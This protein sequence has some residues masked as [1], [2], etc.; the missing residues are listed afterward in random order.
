MFFSKHHKSP[1][2]IACRNQKISSVH[3]KIGCFLG[4]REQILKFHFLWN[5]FNIHTCRF[6]SR[7]KKNRTGTCWKFHI[8]KKSQFFSYQVTHKKNQEITKL[9]WHWKNN[10]LKMYLLLEMVIFQCHVR[11]QGSTH[12]YSPCLGWFQTFPFV[13]PETVS[14][15]PFCRICRSNQIEMWRPPC[16][17]KFIRYIHKG[18]KVSEF[19]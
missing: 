14:L 10:N 2:K 11:F 6:F 3:Q 1:F 9:T 15:K 8:F 16:W 13:A 12:W 7:R 18:T 5:M 4:E 17:E 19:I